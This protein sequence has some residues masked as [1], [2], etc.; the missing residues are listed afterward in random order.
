MEYRE[1]W[2]PRTINQIYAKR[3]DASMAGPLHRADRAAA[4]CSGRHRL[5]FVP[6]AV[7]GT[8]PALGITGVT[9]SGCRLRALFF[10]RKGVSEPLSAIGIEKGVRVSV[11]GSGRN[12]QKALACLNQGLCIGA[13]GCQW[14]LFFALRHIHNIASAFQPGRRCNGKTVRLG[15]PGEKRPH[16][17]RV[18]WLSSPFLTSSAAPGFR[19]LPRIVGLVARITSVSGT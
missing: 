16:G 17:R 15:F 18:S 4:A 3:R 11:N 10:C 1:F 2:S 8:R 7:T 12:D 13:A 9:V 6:E 19:G 14:Q 5:K